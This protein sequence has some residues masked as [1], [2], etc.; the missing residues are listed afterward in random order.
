MSL[1]P[2]PKYVKSVQVARTIRHPHTLV[3]AARM[4]TARHVLQLIPVMSVKLTIFLITSQDI[5]KGAQVDI[6]TLQQLNLARNAAILTVILAVLMEA[7][8][9]PVFLN[10]S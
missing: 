2:V 7:S 10:T 9:V 4:L 8:A 5:V 1:I 6:S 3:K